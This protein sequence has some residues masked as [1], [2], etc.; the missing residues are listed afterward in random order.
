MAVASVQVVHMAA[1]AGGELLMNVEGGD[2]VD[3][4]ERSYDDQQMPRGKFLK[5]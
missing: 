2:E 3:K 1:D 4:G 5:E